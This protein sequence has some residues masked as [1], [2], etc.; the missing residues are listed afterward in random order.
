MHALVE[1]GLYHKGIHLLCIGNSVF[2]VVPIIVQFIDPMKPTIK[3]IFVGGD[4]GEPFSITNRTMKT[5]VPAFPAFHK[6][7]VI[8]LETGRD[9]F[10][11]TRRLPLC[12]HVS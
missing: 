4:E 8:F 10:R 1:T 2:S 12:G 7:S 11:E 6:N 3:K 5:A 9:V